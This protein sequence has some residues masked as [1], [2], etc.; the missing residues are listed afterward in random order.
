MRSIITFFLFVF[1]FVF[2]L[3][4]NT[5]KADGLPEYSIK[6]AYLYN[7]ALL[8]EWPPNKKLSHVNMCFYGQHGF[9]SALDVLQKKKIDSQSI[10]LIDITTAAQIKD[11]HVLFLGEISPKSQQELMQEMTGLP[12]LVITDNIKITSQHV[13]ILMISERERLVFDVNLVA[14]KESGLSLSSKLLR[15]A[16]NV[17]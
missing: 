13:M 7:F 4:M 1:G 12:I 6:A 5:A 17:D 16:R 3:G 14:V 8:A 11:C 2:G 15:L 9:G 10:A